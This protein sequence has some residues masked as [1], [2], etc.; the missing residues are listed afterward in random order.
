[1]WTIY[2]LIAS[3]FLAT[4]VYYNQYAKLKP[5][6]LM[7]YRGFGV[8]LVMLPIALV[9]LPHAD[10]GWKFYLLSA[11]QGLLVGYI[12]NRFFRSSK[13][14][15]AEITGAF[16]PLALALT[17]SFWFVIRP[18]KFFEA[19]STPFKFAIIVLCLVGVTVSV[20]LLRRVKMNK[21]AL[22][23]LLPCVLICGILDTNIKVIMDTPNA[24][25]YFL[26]YYYT[27]ISALFCGLYSL[28][29]YLKKRQKF[30]TLFLKNNLKHG[31]VI[32]FILIGLVFFKGY[33]LS[34][35]SNPAYVVAITYLSPLWISLINYSYNILTKKKI[36][37]RLN[38]KVLVLLVSSIITLVIVAR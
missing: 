31:F 1:M 9:I 34:L 12:D 14:F 26:V 3:F 25:R 21:K 33:S 36:R 4:Y 23:Y 27:M 17:F 20:M 10:F 8:T 37:N 16:Q 32:I 15:G 28:V 35:A 18:E 29:P 11:L 5:L 6:T 13:V 22:L 2:A 19:I 30:K 7:M 38:V 24:N